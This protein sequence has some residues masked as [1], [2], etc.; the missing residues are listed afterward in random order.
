MCQI[1]F[2]I[3][4]GTPEQLR[5][6]KQPW[7]DNLLSSSSREGRFGA[8]YDENELIGLMKAVDVFGLVLLKD[9]FQASTKAKLSK[10]EEFHVMEK[11]LE[12]LDGEGLKFEEIERLVKEEDAE[13]IYYAGRLSWLC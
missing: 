6:H 1:R 10:K 2:Y 12:K 3:G 11:H 5:C 13:G 4:N 8:I 9:G 7:Y